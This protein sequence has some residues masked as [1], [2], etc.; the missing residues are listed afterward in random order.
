MESNDEGARGFHEGSADTQG[1]CGEREKRKAESLKV[2]TFAEALSHA[3][4]EIVVVKILG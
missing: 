4:L 3:R 1:K 2:M